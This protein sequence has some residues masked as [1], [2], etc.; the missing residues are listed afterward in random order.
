MSV[1]K[2]KNI[3]LACTRIGHT[4]QGK[5]DDRTRM[6]LRPQSVNLSPPRSKNKRLTMT[7][8]FRVYE[9][10]FD[11]T[12]TVKM[13][14]RIEFMC[15]C[16]VNI[17]VTVHCPTILLETP[18]TLFLYYLYLP[19]VRDTNGAFWNVVT[20][21]RIVL[22][23]TMRNTQGGDRP[24]AQSLLDKST[25]V[26]KFLVVCKCRQLAATNGFIK[27]GL[28]LLLNVRKGHHG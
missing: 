8:L 7:L 26:W 12:F 18:T 6:S 1:T 15:I 20:F 23:Y 10:C 13:S 28:R 4:G 24:P 9:S 5:F 11:F 22:G 19:Y 3:I 25:D 14:G 16:T 21:V 27:L 2:Y 17:G